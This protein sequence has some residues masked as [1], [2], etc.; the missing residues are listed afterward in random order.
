MS[1]AEAD[2]GG[3]LDNIAGVEA[4]VRHLIRYSDHELLDYFVGGSAYEV[5]KAFGLHPWQV[6]RIRG[7][8]FGLS[9]QEVEVAKAALGWDA[10]SWARHQLGVSIIKARA[11]VLRENFVRQVDI[12]REKAA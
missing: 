8:I 1:D 4:E 3:P 11:E 12:I 9:A 6:Q 2:A 5:S 10:T 7:E